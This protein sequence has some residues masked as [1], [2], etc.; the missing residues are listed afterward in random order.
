[1]LRRFSLYGFLK[2][3][4]YFEPFLVL[5]FLQ[6][7]LNFTLIGFLIAFREITVNLM[8]IPTGGIADVYGRRKSMILSMAAYILSFAIFGAAGLVASGS[9]VALYVLMPV[10]L[11]AML[12]FAIGEAFRTGTHKAMIFTWLRTQGRERERTRIYGYTRSWSKIGSAVSV[13]LACVF[14]FATSNYITIFF[15]SIIPYILNIINFLGY[16]KSVDV[17]TGAH[18]SLPHVMRHL[19]ESLADSWRRPDLRRLMFESMGFEGFFKA[20]KDYLQPIL[21]AAAVPLVAA[22]LVGIEMSDQQKAVVLIGPVYVVLFLASAAA[23]RTVHRLVGK[24]G[25][26]DRTAHRLWGVSILVFLALLS[27]LLFGLYVPIILGFLVLYIMQN[28]WRPVLISRFDTYGDAAKGATLLSIESQ[29]KSVATMIMAPAL[30]AGVDWVKAYKIGG[31]PFWPVGALG[32]VIAVAFFLSG[33]PG[34][35]REEGGSVPES[36]TG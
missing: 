14:V 1:M 8:E 34:R 11:V 9:A 25:G 17:S 30:G 7:G 27:A 16:P 26:E 4:Q 24:H 6:M 35:G 33:R 31:S 32:L 29:A 13:V 36:C 22:L 19:K 5:A 28:L 21:K 15:F 12:F 23:S 3:Q 10:L 20:A 2:N 18:T